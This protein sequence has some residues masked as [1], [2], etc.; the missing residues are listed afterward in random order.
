MTYAMTCTC[1]DVMSVDA[2]SRD[3]AVMKLKEMMG[4]EAISKHFEEKHSGQTPPS[5]AETHAMIE[6]NVKES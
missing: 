6:Q 3:E 5:V 1:G 2:Q 4:E